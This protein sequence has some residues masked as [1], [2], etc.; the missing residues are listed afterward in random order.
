MPHLINFPGMRYDPTASLQ[1]FQHHP[2]PLLQLHRLEP[3]VRNFLSSKQR[4]IDTAQGS[5]HKNVCNT[6]MQ[7]EGMQCHRRPSFCG[8]Y[9]HLHPLCARNHTTAQNFQAWLYKRAAGWKVLTFQEILASS[10]VQ[11]PL[12]TEASHVMSLSNSSSQK[13]VLRRRLIVGCG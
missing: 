3:Q 12:N 1:I 6:E 5:S 8:S 10:V 7:N 2:L 11:M 9:I 4:V 13:R